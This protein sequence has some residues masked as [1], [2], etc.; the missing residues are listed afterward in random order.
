[1]S[2][3]GQTHLSPPHCLRS[4]EASWPTASFLPLE[5]SN[6]S[7]PL[8]IHRGQRK[9]RQVLQLS[10]FTAL[11]K[12]RCKPTLALRLLASYKLVF[13]GASCGTQQ[14]PAFR[15]FPSD[16]SSWRQGQIHLCKRHQ[17]G[18][19][20]AFSSDRSTG[21]ADGKLLNPGGH[22]RVTRFRKERNLHLRKPWLP[23]VATAVRSTGKE[24]LALERQ[25][26]SNLQIL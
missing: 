15:P 5:K 24:G 10:A 9:P 19:K 2:C 21:L 26:R 18:T 20:P 4:C 16:D 13:W 23:V 1:M 6:Y 14:V 12:S 25:E 8:L 17:T 22:W 7:Q 3:E 11:C